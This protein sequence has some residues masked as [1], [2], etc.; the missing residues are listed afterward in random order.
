MIHKIQ[1]SPLTVS[2]LEEKMD[3][4]LVRFTNVMMYIKS[5]TEDK[6]RICAKLPFE[7]AET[8]SAPCK[9]QEDD[10][11]DEYEN[12]D[13]RYGIKHNVNS[14]S[15]LSSAKNIV[16]AS[17]VANVTPKYRIYTGNINGVVVTWQALKKL[18]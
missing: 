2:L 13:E 8:L 6:L 3:V 18:L 1:K 11:L 17:D 9:S 5:L 4:D 10:W 16:M 12:L 15:P 14:A 7:V